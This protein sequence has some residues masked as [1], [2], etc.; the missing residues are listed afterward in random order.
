MFWYFRIYVLVSCSCFVS[1][2][3]VCFRVIL[4]FPLFSK[5]TS[6]I[7][8]SKLTSGIPQIRLEN[9]RMNTNSIPHFK[10]KQREGSKPQHG[11]EEV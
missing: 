5:L 1:F 11:T 9:Q 8:H 2:L 10:L 6:G 4:M 7:P 3:F